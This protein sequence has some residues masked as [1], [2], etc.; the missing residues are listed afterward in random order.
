[1]REIYS[2]IRAAGI[3]IKFDLQE[4]GPYLVFQC[5]GPDAILVEVRAPLESAAPQGTSAST[6]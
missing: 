6:P 1:V 3:G 5:L 2:R 4:A